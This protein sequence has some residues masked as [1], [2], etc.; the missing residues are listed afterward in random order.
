MVTV[1]A[2]EQGSNKVET[3]VTATK[4]GGAVLDLW[5]PDDI[6]DNYHVLQVVR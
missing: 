6:K 3:V 4:K 5:L 2:S 1:A